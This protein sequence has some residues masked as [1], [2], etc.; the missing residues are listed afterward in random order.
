MTFNGTPLDALDALARAR[1]AL[2]TVAPGWGGVTTIAGAAKMLAE[3]AKRM[4]CEAEAI[5][6][7]SSAAERDMK[8]ARAQQEREAADCLR[9]NREAAG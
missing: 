3:K 6:G 8:L 4:Q 1:H 9:V 7:A 2:A 5:R